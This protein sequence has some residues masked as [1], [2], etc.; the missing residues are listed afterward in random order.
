MGKT[1]RAYGEMADGSGR[2]KYHK[3][4]KKNK[5]R[6]ERKKAKRDPSCQPGY[7]KYRGYE[8]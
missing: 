7:G 1:S 6:N 2:S 5:A 3:F 8:L 4:L